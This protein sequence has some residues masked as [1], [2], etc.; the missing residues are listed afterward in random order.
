MIEIIGPKMFLTA[1]TLSLV[2]KVCQEQRTQLL[3][4]T[5][6]TLN[7]QKCQ[8]LDSE[9][10]RSMTFLFC[11][12]TKVKKEKVNLGQTD[13]NFFKKY[14]NKLVMNFIESAD[15][16]VLVQ[17]ES[18]LLQQFMLLEDLQVFSFDFNSIDDDSFQL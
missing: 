7:P 5:L 9:P 2:I 1:T 11:R 15:L 4:M 17:N 12:V 10:T 3:E 13:E 18:E 6:T 14:S 16:K 8:Q